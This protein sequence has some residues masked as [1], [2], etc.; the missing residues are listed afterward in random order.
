V[1]SLISPIGKSSVIAEKNRI[2]RLDLSQTGYY[3]ILVVFRHITCP[4]SAPMCDEN[5]KMKKIALGGI[6]V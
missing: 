2:F 4:L 3:S 1:F 5:R 6:D